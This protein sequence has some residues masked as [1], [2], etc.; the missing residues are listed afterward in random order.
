MFPIKSDVGISSETSINIEY[1]YEK[2]DIR[3]YRAI[4]IANE[5]TFINQNLLRRIKPEELLNLAFLST[6][7]KI[8]A[9]NITTMLEF[10]ERTILLFATQIL[11]H[12]TDKQRASVIIHLFS[13][14]QQ[15]YIKNHDI[16][17]IR[18]IL[19]TFDHPSVFRLRET[20]RIFRR[21]NPNFYTAFKYLWNVLS[22]ENNWSDYRL[23]LEEKFI[24]DYDYRSLS[25]LSNLSYAFRQGNFITYSSNSC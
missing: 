25:I 12:Q 3:Q 1:K 15:L 22:Q 7:K 23:W 2:D 4:E 5:L 16:H 11:R 10:Y 19:A 24:K 9:P 21:E 17:S 20:W 6:E 13:V 14:I 8:L 18:I